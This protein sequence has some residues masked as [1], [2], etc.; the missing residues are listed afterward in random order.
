MERALHSHHTHGF[1]NPN[2][3]LCSS[4]LATS[5]AL[6]F[7]ASRSSHTQEAQEKEVLAIRSMRSDRLEPGKSTILG[8][9]DDYLESR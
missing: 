2:A 7:S 8:S 3:H 1:D 6:A 4:D 9:S 5:H